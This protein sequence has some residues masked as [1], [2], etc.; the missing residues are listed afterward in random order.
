MHSF[1]QWA[2]PLHLPLLQGGKCAVFALQLLGYECDP[3]YSVQLSNHAGK[4]GAATMAAGL[5]LLLL[6]G[7]IPP[8]YLSQGHASSSTDTT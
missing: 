5:R 8:L 7:F 6:W 3:I 1:T 2:W 4:T